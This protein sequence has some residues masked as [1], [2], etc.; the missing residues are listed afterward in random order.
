MSGKCALSLT[1]A[2][3]AFHRV[4]LL[5]ERRLNPPEWVDRVLGAVPGHPDRL[6][7]KHEHAAELQARTVTNLSNARSAWLDNTRKALD[8]LGR[9]R[10]RVDRLTAGG[11]RRGDAGPAPGSRS[12]VLGREP[13]AGPND[14][15]GF[16][17][18]PA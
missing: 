8:A 16:A 2:S 5:R 1:Q 14:R 15:G 6:T 13:A 3:L 4:N 9:R 18:S 17:W 12:D 10:L 11:A 7:P